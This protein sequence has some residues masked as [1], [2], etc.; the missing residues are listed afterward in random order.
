M[1]WL[2]DIPEWL[3][4]ALIGAVFAVA[5]YVGKSL[6]DWRKQKQKERAKTLAQ[7]EGLNSLLH[8]SGVLFLLQQEQVKRLRAMLKEN[9]P[10]EFGNGGPYEDVMTR[11]NPMMNAA[12]RTLHNIIRASTEHSLR[13]VNQAV[14]D[15]LKTDSTFKTSIAP[16]SRRQELA[17]QLFALEIHLLLWHAKYESWIPNHPEHALVYLADENEHGLGFPTEQ[18]REVN[19]KIEQVPGVQ[20]EVALALKELREQWRS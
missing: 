17:R 1:K 2:G 20:G 5:G 15:W 13:K 10:T 9:H 7:L 12:E 4:T 16:T 14:S 18:E 8:A 11:C 6:V 19:G 3:A